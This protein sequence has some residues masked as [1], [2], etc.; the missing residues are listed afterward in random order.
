M[1]DKRRLL[2]L[3]AA[4]VLFA[5]S[6]FIADGHAAGQNFDE[7]GWQE[8]GHY[9]YV[10]ADN[11]TYDIS[12]T[13]I[14]ETAKREGRLMVKFKHAGDV[15][16]TAHINSGFAHKRVYLMHVTGDPFDENA[17]N[18]SSF[19]EEI[20]KLVNA[21]RAKTGARPLKLASDLSN[22]AGIRAKEIVNKFSHSRPDGRDFY[23]VLLR[24]KNYTLGENIA[25]GRAS[26][27]LV[28]EDWMNSPGHR[29]NI[30]NKE[31]KELGV[32]YCYR[33]NSTYEHYWV[34][35]FRR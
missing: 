3:L 7:E 34:Q 5:Q 6:F 15:Y 12:N 25:A 8:T 19:A 9:W 16:I 4:F 35:I 27:A 14:A 28:M 2:P 11:V 31:Y 29:K 13:N 10:L 20:L 1:I 30:L 32:G 18:R 17:V 22:A 23:T 24:G 21:E 33:Q 26:A